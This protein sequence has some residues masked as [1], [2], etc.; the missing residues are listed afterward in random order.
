[1]KPFSPPPRPDRV[2]LAAPDTAALEAGLDRCLQILGE[3]EAEVRAR[4]RRWWAAFAL[5][6]VIA[7]VLL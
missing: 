6:L 5:G 2:P 3:L 4:R 1:M 7:L